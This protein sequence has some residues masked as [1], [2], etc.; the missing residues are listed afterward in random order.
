[1]RREVMWSAWDDPGL[2][3]L[4]LG[5]HDEDIVADGMVIGVTE[6]HPFRVTYKV[7]CDVRWR[8][9]AVRVGVPGSEPPE[10]ALLSD[11]E[12]NWTTPDGRA[13]S[14]LY[15][16][17]DVDISVTPFTNTLPI[18]RLG[19]VPTESAEISVAYIQDTSLQAWPEPQRYTC[20]KKD[21]QGGLY[22][23]L[24]LDGGFTAD[25]PV[26]ADGLVLDYPGLF[27]RAFQD[28]GDLA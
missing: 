27:R 16:C 9:R 2:E 17:L 10:V 13:V 8:V 15:G 19:L 11:G 7:R 20:L 14:E 4:R 1:V 24:S 6:G 28:G 3:H 21:N 25:L 23:F 18:R 26:D 22:G 12:G 5:M